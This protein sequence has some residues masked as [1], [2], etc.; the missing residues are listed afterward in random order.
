M[1][2]LLFKIVGSKVFRAG[3]A[4]CHHVWNQS[5]AIDDCSRTNPLK[6]HITRKGSKEIKTRY[7]CRSKKFHLQPCLVFD[8]FIFRWT[9]H[10]CDR[11]DHRA[12]RHH[13]SHD[14][15]RNRRSDRARR[16]HR[17]YD[18]HRNRRLDHDCRHHKSYD[19]HDHR[20]GIGRKHIEQRPRR[21]KTKQTRKNLNE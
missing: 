14:L 7:H 12:H 1:Q 16:H 15:H 5:I 4:M 18:L 2:K 3:K 9:I 20:V 17:S 6:V 13:R 19:L 11:L 8:P 21:P 10:K